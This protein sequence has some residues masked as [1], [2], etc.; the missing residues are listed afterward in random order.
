MMGVVKEY[1][2]QVQE[3]MRWR[4]VEREKKRERGKERVEDQMKRMSWV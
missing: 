3:E 1:S 2:V 4:R